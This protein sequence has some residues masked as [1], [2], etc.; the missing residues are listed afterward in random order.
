VYLELGDE[1]TLTVQEYGA[2]VGADIDIAGVYGIVNTKRDK[3]N[4]RTY[5]WG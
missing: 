4:D 1:G 5:Q 2:L 3:N